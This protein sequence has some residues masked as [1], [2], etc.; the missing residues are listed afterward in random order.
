MP[1]RRSTGAPRS[2]SSRP[3]SSAARV[4]RPITNM[5]TSPAVIAPNAVACQATCPPVVFSARAGPAIAMKAA[6]ADMAAAASS[7]ASWL[8]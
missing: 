4:W 8:V 5:L 6:L 3:V 2:S 7:N 1:A